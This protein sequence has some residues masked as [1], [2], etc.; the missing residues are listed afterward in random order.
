MNLDPPTELKHFEDWETRGA[1]I[2]GFR[3]MS[4]LKSVNICY[5]QKHRTCNLEE[6]KKKKQHE[7]PFCLASHPKAT[8]TK[9]WFQVSDKLLSLCSRSVTVST[10]KSSLPSTLMFFVS[11]LPGKKEKQL[12]LRGGHSSWKI[13]DTNLIQFSSNS[14]HLQNGSVLWKNDGQP[15]NLG[16]LCFQTNAASG[17]PN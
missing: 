9:L 6:R 10:S 17:S 13:V 1:E 5:H 4:E 12:K 16:V 8:V 15:S 11:C 7:N 3:F 14:L 2:P